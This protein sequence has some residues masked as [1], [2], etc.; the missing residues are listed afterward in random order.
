MGRYDGWAGGRIRSGRRWWREF[1][2]VRGAGGGGRDDAARGGQT[3]QKRS[4]Q[5]NNQPSRG[6]RQIKRLQCTAPG[7]KKTPEEPALE[8]DR[9]GTGHKERA[10]GRLDRV[11]PRNGARGERKKRVRGRQIERL[12]VREGVEVAVR[13]QAKQTTD[14]RVL[15]C[16]CCCC[17][18]CC[19]C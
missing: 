15:P 12:R 3:R 9:I 18:C 8:N 10:G 11:R 1:G 14:D 5:G 2:G 19:C 13:A 7:G 17:C 16:G 4:P 6:R